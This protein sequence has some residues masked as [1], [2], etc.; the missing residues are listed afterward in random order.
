MD[1]KIFAAIKKLR[2]WS[3]RKICKR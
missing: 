2:F 3:T 1:W